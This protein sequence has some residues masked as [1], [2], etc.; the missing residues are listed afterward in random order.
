MSTAI[1]P[2]KIAESLTAGDNE[3]DEEL[4]GWASLTAEGN[5]VHITFTPA[6]ETETGSEEDE[7][8]AVHFRAVVAAVSEAAAWTGPLDFCTH[9]SKGRVTLAADKTLDLSPEEAYAAAVQLI[10]AAALAVQAE[11]QGGEA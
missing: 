8:E 10:A 6:R 1:T 2:A 7:D 9:P 4:D 3:Y 11:A 5:V